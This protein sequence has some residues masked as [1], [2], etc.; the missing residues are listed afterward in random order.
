[1]YEAARLEAVA[2]EL[3]A[4][5]VGLS[6]KPRREALD[7]L[8]RERVCLRVTA[9][10]LELRVLHPKAKLLMP[11]PVCRQ[12]APQLVERDNLLVV[13]ELLDGEERVHRRGEPALGDGGE[14][15]LVAERERVHA[16]L[17]RVTERERQHERG[18]DLREV[19]LVLAL[20]RNAAV[21]VVVED[22]EVLAL[23]VVEGGGGKL[24]LRGLPHDLDDGLR[25]VDPHGARAVALRARQVLEAAPDEQVAALL[26][27][28]AH[29]LHRARHALLAHEA[30]RRVLA[31]HV[32]RLPPDLVRRVLRHLQ[33]ELRR[34]QGRL[35]HH[36]EDDERER[37]VGARAVLVRAAKVDGVAPVVVDGPELPD[38]VAE[39]LAELGLRRAAGREVGLVV[40]P[41]ANIDVV[42][43]AHLEVVERLG[44]DEVHHRELHHVE[45]RLRRP[46]AQAFER[47][48]LALHPV[49]TGVGMR[50]R[51]CDEAVEEAHHRGGG[52]LLGAVERRVLRVGVHA[53][54]HAGE[55]ELQDVDPVRRGVVEVLADGGA[56]LLVHL[57]DGRAQA[58]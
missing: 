36:V 33:L 11:L 16:L 15:V 42:E 54:L 24:A 51:S 8:L 34:R 46:R 52:P 19:P 28:E 12:D 14:V 30:E 58:G 13:D 49:R 57:G 32:E 31:Q 9:P 41:P 29:R 7:D 2:H 10:P 23:E 39:V 25:Q 17:E 48:D 38:E 26:V 3:A 44:E 37:I 18:V 1:M 5:P 22:A 27:R 43:C 53:R 40:G 21:R 47:R 20:K 50:L 6:D 55:A 4:A 35:L 45:H 56:A